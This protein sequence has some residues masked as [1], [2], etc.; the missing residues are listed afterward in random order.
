MLLKSLRILNCRKI[1][2]ADIEFHGPG[3]QVIQGLNESGKSTLA[4]SI[5][6][7]FGGSKEVTPGMITKGQEQA[8]IIAIT[9]NELKIRTQIQGTTVKQTVYQK[10]DTTGRY[11]TVTGGV[12]TFLDSMRSGLEM[13][14]AMRNMTDAQIIEILKNRAGITA[15]IAEIDASIKTKE[16]AR[17][18]TG[19]D[20]K[21]LGTP[22][23]VKEA[24]HPDPI[25]AI[26]EEKGK[27]QE[28]IKSVHEEYLKVS[29]EIRA[30]CDFKTLDEM[31]QVSAALMAHVTRMEKALAKH[32]AYTQD[33]LDKL[34]NQ[35]ADWLKEEQAAKDFDEYTKK[36][37]QVEQLSKDYDS[38]TADI[39]ALRAERKKTLSEMKLGV[40][41][42]TIGEEDNLLY[43]NGVVRG[44]TDTNKDGNWSTAESI[45][46]FFTVG[47][48]FSGDLKVL[49]VDNAESLD[50]TAIKHVSKWAETA[51]FLVILLKVASVPED[52]EDGIIYI[53]EGEVITK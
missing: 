47:A 5:A 42:L 44:I 41:G 43:H 13:P 30:K 24:K 2:Q 25:D 49:V 1:R 33:D 37:A 26:R 18:E 39:D 51:K 53:R 3:K 9:D 12:R 22:D 45:K 28:Y 35:I 19:R 15:K 46:V 40:D 20:K 29:N 50:E 10:D 34:D 16:T 8:E 23:P 11:V 17:T 32:K 38:L 21:R 31:R 52:L 36:K 27:A 7:T 6:I 14:W 48:A 4:Q